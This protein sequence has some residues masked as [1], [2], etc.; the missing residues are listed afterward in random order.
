LPADG[1]LWWGI[2]PRQ[3]YQAFGKR[4]GKK[5]CRLQ[6]FTLQESCQLAHFMALRQ[7]KY[8]DSA[9]DREFRAAEDYATEVLKILAKRLCEAGY[10]ENFENLDWAG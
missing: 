10:L 1:G 9:A 3:S 8:L 6:Y 5:M 4:K 7:N 2:S